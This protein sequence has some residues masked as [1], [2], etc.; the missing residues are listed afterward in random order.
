M[1]DMLKSQSVAPVIVFNNVN[2]SRFPYFSPLSI[3][4]KK[5]PTGNL[6]FGGQYNNNGLKKLKTLGVTAI[7]NMRS[8]MVHDAPRDFKYLH[9][10][11]PD[12]NPPCVDMLMQGAEFIDEEINSGGK[13]YINCLKGLGRGPTMVVAFLIKTGKSLDDAV[14]MVKRLNSDISLSPFQIMR[15]QDLEQLYRKNSY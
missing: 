12:N 5:T 6:Y 2:R 1:L 4:N 11:T 13:V 9:L 10:P 8:Q 14:A 7:V 15:L 3:F